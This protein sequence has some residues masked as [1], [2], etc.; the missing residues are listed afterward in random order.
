VKKT[1]KSWDGIKKHARTEYPRRGKKARKTK[2]EEGK[3]ETQI[4]GR[5]RE[6]EKRRGK[7]EKP[8]SPDAKGKHLPPKK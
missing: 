5:Q 3:G 8:I 7:R 1:S 4:E 6:G 2:R